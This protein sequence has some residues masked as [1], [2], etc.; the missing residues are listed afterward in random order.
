[1]DF[2]KAQQ[3][4]GIGHR[5]AI[6]SRAS[7]DLFLGEVKLAHHALEG[8][9]LFNRVQIFALDILHQRD[10][11]RGLV[12][13]LPDDGWDARQTGSLSRTPASL[14]S[15]KLKARTDGPQN[16]RLDDAGGSELIVPVRPAPLLENRVRG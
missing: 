6:L 8:A 12:A 4:H 9:C 15:Q 3:A 7:G 5:R 11:K 2:S 14:A 10:F 13:D 1:M 16:Q